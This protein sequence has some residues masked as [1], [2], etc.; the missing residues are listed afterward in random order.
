MTELEIRNALG[1]RL[2]TLGYSVA[3]ENVS[4]LPT[5]P[6]VAFQVVRVSRDTPGLN[7][8]AAV[9]RGYMVATV[10]TAIGGH[11][12]EALTMADAIIAAFP[13]GLK[14]GGLAVASSGALEGFR[15]GPD[16]RLPVR[17]DYIAA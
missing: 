13:K 12:T 2:D 14:L 6:Y 17:V 15:D 5:V 4:E 9:S 3:W 8:G 11:D 10:V 16:W 1:Q 7:G